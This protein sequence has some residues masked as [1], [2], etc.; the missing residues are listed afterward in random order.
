MQEKTRKKMLHRLTNPITNPYKQ[1]EKF[2]M[3]PW[4]DGSSSKEIT[5]IIEQEAKERPRS[6]LIGIQAIELLL[7]KPDNY[8]LVYLVAWGANQSLD[9]PQIDSI[10]WLQDTIDMIKE[11]LRKNGHKIQ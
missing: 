6:L 11:I 3:Y 7:A 8:D 1:A 2:L 5:E 10:P 9:D 4:A